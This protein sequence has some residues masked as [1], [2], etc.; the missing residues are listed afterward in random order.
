MFTAKEEGLWESTSKVSAED[1]RH[2][3]NRVEEFRF[4]KIVTSLKEVHSCARCMATWILKYSDE[5]ATGS[6]PTPLLPTTT[7]MSRIHS[8]NGFAETMA[9][10]KLSGP[11]VET[12]LADVVATGAVHVRE[13]ALSDWQCLPSWPSLRVMEARRLGAV[14]VAAAAPGAP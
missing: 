8:A 1:V 13:L 9:A 14:L 6:V 10:A 11:I 4:Q 3:Q 5:A 2:I 12:L 7:P